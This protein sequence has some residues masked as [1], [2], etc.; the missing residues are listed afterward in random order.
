VAVVE[1]AVL[2]ARDLGA[3]HAGLRGV[4][5]TVQERAGEPLVDRV[6]ELA[7]AAEVSA[8]ASC[9]KACGPGRLLNERLV[10]EKRPQ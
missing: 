5:R 4:A 6:L 7:A 1:E 2:D 3:S 10:V 9:S 8:Q